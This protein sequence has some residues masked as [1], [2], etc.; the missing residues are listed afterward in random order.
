MTYIASRPEIKV[1]FSKV[2]IYQDTF[3]PD[4]LL[5]PTPEDAYNQNSI[6]SPGRSAD[7]QYRM[8]LTHDRIN[9]SPSLFI[10]RETLLS[11]R[12]FDERF[13]LV[14]DYPL[15]LN[16]TKNDYKLYFMDKVTV[17]YRRHLEAINNIGSLYMVKPNY[18]NSERLRKI[19]TYPYLPVDI[20]LNQRFNWYVLQIFRWNWL[21]RNVKPNRFLLVLLTVYINP[22]RYYIWLKKH[23][24][25]KLK[26]NEFYK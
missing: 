12:G 15:W 17:N 6:V 11:I 8:L 9:Y 5:G 19:Y 1:L 2:E 22:F 18:F 24:R 4:N 21:N 25:K 16:L 23:I 26:Y 13:R 10:N 7:S 14:E 20:R 3:E